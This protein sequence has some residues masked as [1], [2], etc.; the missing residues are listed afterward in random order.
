MEPWD[1][2]ASVTF[3][4]GKVIGAVLDRNGLRPS[5]YWV[6]DDDLVVMASEVG[7][8]DIDP[9]KVVAKGRLQPG[10]MFLIDTTEGRIV[11]DSEIK[12]RLAAEHPYGEWLRAGLVDLPDLPD[13]EHVVFSHDS[14]LRR[15]QMFGYTHEELKMLITP[16]AAKGQEA[17]GSMG[18]DTPLAVLSDRPRLVFDYFS[19]LFAQ[20]TNPP[21][22][23]IREEVVTATASTVGP[24]ANL[25][26]PGPESC[27]QL[28]LPYP[29]IDNDELAKI[30][31]IN[32]DGQYPGLQARV[33]SGLYRVADGGEGLRL[34]LDR[35]CARGV[36]GD[37]GRGTDPRA[38]GSQRRLGRGADPV[39][40]A[41]ERGPPPPRAH[42]AADDGRPD[43][44]G[45]RCPRGPPHGAADR[46]RRRRDQPVPGV[47]VDRGPDRPTGCTTSVVST[48]SRRSGTTS[49]P[50]ARASSR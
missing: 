1:G 29:I 26:A 30:I 45:R 43:R 19:Q 33:L 46:L 40:A 18:T 35:I 32:D 12:A 17:L 6:T 50:A 22:D 28:H 16:M 39:A 36:R 10:K 34:A 41:D 31:H 3:T 42:Q 38:V 48:R 9:A 7:V 25:L 11:D 21:L 47:R 15:Q 14:V 27:R 2:P 4:D 23:A 49:R 44:R 37:R 5:R 20:V 24:E 13:R 8:I